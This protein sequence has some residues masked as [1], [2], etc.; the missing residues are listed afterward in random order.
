MNR[1]KPRAKADSVAGCSKLPSPVSMATIW[2]VTVVIDSNGLAVSRA[3]APAAMTT[4]IVSPMA[5]LTASITPATIPGSAAGI[6]TRRIVSE[7]VAPIARLPSRIACGTAAIESSAIE[8]TKGMIM[9]PMTRPAAI[10]LS[11]DALAIPIAWAAS[12]TAGATVSAA[13]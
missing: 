1:T 10:A 12:R 6:S 11:L 5:R 4:I 3:V 8:E 2:N 13:K 9:M 7:V